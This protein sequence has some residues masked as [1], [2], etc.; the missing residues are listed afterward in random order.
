MR[1]SVILF[2][3]I[4][5]LYILLVGLKAGLGLGVSA[6]EIG[7]LTFCIAWVFGRK[8]LTRK[9]LKARLK[10]SGD[11]ARGVYINVSSNGIIWGGEGLKQ[12]HLAWQE[13]DH[14]IKTLNGFI[15]GT[16]VAKFLWCPFEGFDKGAKEPFEQAL[17]EHQVKLMEVKRSC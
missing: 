13:V 8:F 10:H 15:I 5:C 7:L 16:K 4:G 17:A 6:A 1:I 9:M 2:N 11:K 12:G 3:F 14:V